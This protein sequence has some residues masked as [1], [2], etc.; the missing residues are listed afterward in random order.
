MKFFLVSL[1]LSFLFAQELEVDGGLKV[2]GE[3]DA[4]GNVLTN[5]GDPVAETDAVNLRS[6]DGLGGMKPERIYRVQPTDDTQY[7]TPE[8]KFWQL[9]INYDGSGY[10]NTYGP[11]IIINGITL[12]LWETRTTSGSND[13]PTK[14]FLL[15]PNDTFNCYFVN[16]EQTYHVVIFEYAIT[17]SGT[18]QGMDYIVP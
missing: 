7:T 6:L 14:Q 17:E 13:M 9:F 4:T 11:K 3:I 12:K 1:L 18:E 8:N 10:L 5:L 16:N 15:L 2:T